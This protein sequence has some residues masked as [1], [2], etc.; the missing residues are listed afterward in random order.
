MQQKLIL[1]LQ[2]DSKE[3]I[4]KE[5]PNI[6]WIF[7]S[8][9]YSHR[10]A[11]EKALGVEQKIIYKTQLT[12]ISYAMR[13]E[14]V[15]FM[16]ELGKPHW[17]HWEWWI[18]PLANRSMA[19]SSL[20]LYLCYLEVLKETLHHREKP[21]IIVLESQLLGEII[22]HHFKE[23][24]DRVIGFNRSIA[25]KI[26]KITGD[27]G[28]FILAW[29]YFFLTSL[30][31][32]RIAK[33]SRTKNHP[34]PEY[35][36][37]PNHVII[38]SCLSDTCFREDGSFKDL[39]FTGLTSYLSE[40][41]FKVSTFVWLYNVQ[42]KSFKEAINWLRSH[43][44]SFLMPEDYF[45][46]WDDIKSFFILQKSTW[47]KLNQKKC[48]YRGI[49]VRPLLKHEQRKQKINTSLVFF[50]NQASMFKKWKKLGYSIKYSLMLWE[51]KYC[52]VPI[53]VGL[54]KHYP[55]CTTFAY[56][57]GALI[58]KLL[59]ANY[60]ITK[61]E[62]THSPHADFG[63]VNS[64][65][66]LEFLSREG[67]S[68]SYLKLSPAFRYKYLENSTNQNMQADQEKNGILLVLPL[69]YNTA[70]E[71]LKLCFEAF[72]CSNYTIWVK[73]HPAMNFQLLKDELSHEWPKQFK[74]IEG[75]MSEWLDQSKIVIVNESGSMV[76]SI[77]HNIPT[78][79][80]CK[81]TDIDIVSIDTIGPNKLG[82]DN[83][84]RMIYSSDQLKEV[85]DQLYEDN[86]KNQELDTQRFF[87]FNMDTL[88]DIF[89]IH[90]T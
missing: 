86:N 55:E 8:R 18:T 35:V 79:I 88:L 17:K 72:Q 45:S 83:S 52:E 13:D 53:V 81:E 61:E 3:K 71:L 22:Y 65:S 37:D 5:Y 68:L 9:D 87:E 1:V 63:L 15:E 34:K 57:P 10:V 23:Q 26:K 25:K 12:E 80:I 67:F 64:L 24:I 62:F 75:L 84:F 51:H 19:I 2:E 69:M 60:K 28:H 20:Y 74:V 11:W 44:D 48:I 58:P 47:F 4:K 50:T 89:H 90:S 41:G 76:E 29:G 77:Y 78:L 70:Y 39:Y 30:I 6:E 27:T 38:H 14:F 73:Y 85:V 46:L 59:F 21:L 40:H 16:A 36:F 42:K 7:F 49:N 54:K 82:Q 43:Q 66:N 56:Q 33:K 32:R 31:K